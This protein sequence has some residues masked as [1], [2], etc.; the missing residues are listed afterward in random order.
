MALD[1]YIG[2]RSTIVDNQEDAV[3]TESTRGSVFIFGTSTRGVNN[4]PTDPGISDVETIFGEVPLDS[5]FDT[6]LVRGYYE[7]K[8][9]CKTDHPVYLIRVGETAKASLS[10]REHSLANTSGNTSS[11]FDD[12]GFPVVALT[13]TAVTAGA[14]Y[15][16]TKVTVAADKTTNVPN[17]M[18]IELNDGTTVGFNLSMDTS[19]AGV[20]ST[21]SDLVDRINAHTDL[22]GKIVAS[23]TPIT[24]DI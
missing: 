7:F 2:V 22:S 14:E 16:G 24:K 8:Q 15:N 11:T 21:V 1:D 13:I 9:S 4:T 17:H 12:D 18:L 23:Y 3:G 5:T 10:L 20:I 19:A 6:S